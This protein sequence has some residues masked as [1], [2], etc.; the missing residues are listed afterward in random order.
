MSNDTML[1]QAVMAELEWEPSVTAAHIGVTASNGIV[2][3][4]GHVRNYTQKLAA[5]RAAGRVKGVKAVAEEIEVKL[6]SD[7]RRS[8]EQIAAAAVDSLAWDVMVPNDKVKVRVEKGW[9]TL[10]GDVHWH[11]QKDAAE[12]DT[13]RLLGV[14]GVSNMIGIK[15]EVRAADIKQKITTA[16]HRTWYDAA[17]ITVASDEGRISLG[18][19]VRSWHE[20]RLAEDAAWGAPGVTQ[21][22]DN[23][24]VV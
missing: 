5:E 20:R 18:G 6:D 14:L 17:Q 2:T 3:L 13:R 16:L 15:P 8:D 21:V 7:M 4:T 19:S 9:V 23:I 1:Q 10:S 22:T 11:Y 24:S 12:D